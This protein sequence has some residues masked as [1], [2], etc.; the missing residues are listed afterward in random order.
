ME[1]INKSKEHITELVCAAFDTESTGLAVDY[2]HKQDVIDLQE[3]SFVVQLA[4]KI[5]RLDYAGN[6]IELHRNNML[7]MP[8]GRFNN[9]FDDMPAEA[10]AVHGHTMA[11]LY[12]HGEPMQKVLLLAYH[13]NYC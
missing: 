9:S 6:I 11:Q 4:Y 8:L 10:L 2:W 1:H 7:V 12:E 5:F 3:M 13:Q